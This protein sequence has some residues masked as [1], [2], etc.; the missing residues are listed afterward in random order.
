MS[1]LSLLPASF[2]IVGC[3]SSAWAYDFPI[4]P[5]E[6]TQQLIEQWVATSEEAQLEAHYDLL[7]ALHR[8][9]KKD[10]IGFA[11]QVVYYVYQQPQAE[12]AIELFAFCRITSRDRALALS[13]YL[14]S[15][16]RRLRK[17]VQGLFPFRPYEFMPSS[18]NYPDYSYLGGFVVDRAPSFDGAASLRRMMFEFS[19]N[20][21]FLQYHGEAPG[22]ERLGLRRMER[23]IADAL[24]E[25]HHLGGLPGG[26]I[27]DATASV[28]RRL[29]ESEHWWARMFAAEIMV[30][31]KEFRDPEVI[32]R[33]LKDENNL[34]SQSVASIKAPDPRRFT[35]VDD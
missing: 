32:D 26:E 9:A 31:N 20:A 1:R 18:Y 24:Y 25:K 13:S 5:D 4:V 27:D 16:D 30:Q 12:L 14:Y 22:S 6:T 35:K 8:L 10:R 3:C 2:V 17:Q 19:P 7:P 23:F 28:I 29:G 15:E 33:L 21:A 34:V 11:R